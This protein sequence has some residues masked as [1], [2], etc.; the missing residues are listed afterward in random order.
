MR[1]GNFI[2]PH[3]LHI[4]ENNFPNSGSGIILNRFHEKNQ[5]PVRF[6]YRK[7]LSRLE[8]KQ[9]K[10]INKNPNYEVVFP[11]RCDVICQIYLITKKA[12]HNT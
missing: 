12:N 11:S 1:T 9:H 3:N 2:I 4:V 7:L 6:Q 10:P 5:L 8:T